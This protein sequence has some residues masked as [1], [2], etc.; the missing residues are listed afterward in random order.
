MNIEQL[1]KHVKTPRPFENGTSVM[2]TDPYISA[3]LLELHIDPDTDTASRSR[4]KIRSIVEWMLPRAESRHGPGPLDIL[5]LGCGPGLYAEELASRG[6]RVTGIDFSETSI[7]FAR[8]KSARTGSDIA[9]R[10]ENYLDL[11]DTG[12][13]DLAIMIYLDFCVLKPNE[14]GAVLENIRRALKPGGIFIFDV[15]NGRNIADKILRPSWEVCGGNGF[16]KP[17]P[18]IAL[19]G[20]FHFPERKALLNRHIV[21]DE[22]DR[23]ETYL[24]W[25]IYYDEEDISPV[26]RSG[27]F[28]GIGRHENTLPPGDAWNGENVTFYTARKV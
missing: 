14:R 25:S 6:H 18:Y 24:F 16:W 4:A 26:L 5:D 13:Y 27:G 10:C 23:V 1:L 2:W 7:A 12:K 15:V 21:I 20:G 11:R 22:E 3:K 28:G 19:N 8:E 9:Y 17:G